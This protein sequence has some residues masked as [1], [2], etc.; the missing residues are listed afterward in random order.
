MDEDTVPLGADDPLVEERL[1]PLEEEVEEPVA[2]DKEPPEPEPKFS[3]RER[4]HAEADQDEKDETERVV[5]ADEPLEE[6]KGEVESQE[7]PFKEALE[8]VEA[9][10]PREPAPTRATTRVHQQQLT[11][12]TD[13][14]SHAPH[15]P[16]PG[17]L[18]QLFDDPLRVADEAPLR[19][20]GHPP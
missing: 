6:Q 14:K 16:L 3:T 20:A 13:L 19:G 12:P 1:E 2:A 17:P 15:T 4:P 9:Q 5:V 8:K 11:T 7:R 18:L 10:P